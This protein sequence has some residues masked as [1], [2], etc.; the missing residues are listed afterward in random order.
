MEK[1]CVKLNWKIVRVWSSASFKN[2]GF[3]YSHQPHPNGILEPARVQK[4]CPIRNYGQNLKAD[5]N[6]CIRT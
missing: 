3:S 5:Y 4:A 1:L 6:T 2:G